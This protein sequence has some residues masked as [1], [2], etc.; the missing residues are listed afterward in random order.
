VSAVLAAHQHPLLISS[1]V[2][3]QRPGWWSRT[4]KWVALG[5][6]VGAVAGLGAIALH[7][8]LQ[9][10]AAW[11]LEGVAGYQPATVAA[12]GGSVYPASPVRRGWVLP[13]I[14]GG[15]ALV[16]ALLVRW[17]APEAASHG[18]DAASHGMD[19]AIRAVHTDPKGIRG[20]VALA[21]LVA[22]ALTLGSGGS[23][24]TEGPA[25]QM[26]VAFGSVVSRIF[27]LSIRDARIAATAG[28]AAGVGAIFRA[29]L[30]GALL[31]GEVL[32]RDDMTLEALLP[33]LVASIVAYAEFGAVFG[34]GPTFGSQA[35]LSLARPIDLALF[36]ALGAVAG[37]LGRLYGWSF[38]AVADWFSRWRLP[39][40]FRP[41]MAGLAVGALGLLLPQVLST[42]YGN[43]QIAMDRQLL[44]TMPLW[45]V[46]ALPF[47]KVLATSLSIGSGGSG[48]VFGPG[49]VIG[50]TAG[51]ACWRLLEPL[52]LAPHSPVSFVLAGVA[53]CLGAI[54]HLPIAVTVMVAE[55]SGSVGILE[56]ATVAVVVATLAVGNATIYRSQ[57]PA[58]ADT[59]PA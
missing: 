20:R 59:E 45:V 38:Y 37:L 49:M 3:L 32:Y 21:K 57:L 7:E 46:L 28:L 25:G 13:L 18:V 43:V 33:S 50:A 9:L 8:L 36:V 53:A 23:G 29:P 1:L 10:G 30:G 34:Y 41:A 14:A 39:P 22:S 48:G 17:L 5:M 26:G 6:V 2:V 27:G 58:R 42:G 52:G 54:T 44:M 35:S 51:A 11:L 12:D 55:V 15:G 19:A 40:M 47:A 4:F 56:P 31:G 16:G 24:G